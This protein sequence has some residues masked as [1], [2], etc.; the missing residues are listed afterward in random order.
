MRPM[1]DIIKVA[2]PVAA[3]VA[4]VGFALPSYIG[5]LKQKGLGRG[6]LILLC[7]SAFILIMETIAVKTG[8]PY[9]KFSYGGAIGY[10]I[11]GAT[12]WPIAFAYTPLLLGAFWLARKVTEKKISVLLVAL[13]ATV[14]HFVIDPG[15]ARMELWKWETAGPFYGVPVMNFA[16]WFITAL[17]GATLLTYLWG[18]TKVR[19]SLG[20]SAFAIVWFWAGVNLG[21]QQWI[22]GA[23]GIAVG[24]LLL[25]MMWTE[26]R[27]EAKAKI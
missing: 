6:A 16:G 12:P 24:F 2:T 22:P 25:T 18:D 19:R 4:I 1:N 10:K 8:L 9:G 13:F 5:V 26:K 21:L 17:V 7:L 15:L 3:A 20:Y 23:I 14:A 27:R 11:L